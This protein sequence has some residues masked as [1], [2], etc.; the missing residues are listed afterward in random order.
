M[1]KLRLIAAAIFVTASAGC[2]AIAQADPTTPPAPVAVPAAAP[3]PHHAGIGSFLAQL[4]LTPDQ[5]TKV[6]AVDANSKA[7]WQAAKADTSLTPAELK[8]K[9][10]QIHKETVKGILAVLTREQKTKLKALEKAAKA[11]EAA[12]APAPAPAPAANP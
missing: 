4:G 1:N 10:V 12:P 2:V 6:K 9:A 7:E 8:A 5:K 11:N 3:A